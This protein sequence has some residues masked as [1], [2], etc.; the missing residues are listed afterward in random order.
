MNKLV[1]TDIAEV[2]NMGTIKKYELK[3]E[4]GMLVEV[5]NFG[6][7]VTKILVPDRDGILDDVTV[8]FENPLDYHRRINLDKYRY[9]Y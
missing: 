9:S 5:L 3:N 7:I 6:G 2:E 4:N 8:G 1:I